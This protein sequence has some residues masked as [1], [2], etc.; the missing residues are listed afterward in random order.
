MTHNAISCKLDENKI[1]RTARITGSIV[2]DRMYVGMCVF[3]VVASITE[4]GKR[5]CHL[6]QCRD[7]RGNFSGHK[8]KTNL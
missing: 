7:G 8:S 3:T 5:R 6:H 1:L 4:P 2:N